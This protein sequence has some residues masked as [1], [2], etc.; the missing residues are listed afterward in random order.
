MCINQDNILVSTTSTRI[1]QQISFRFAAGFINLPTQNH[2][3]AEV[4]N[5]RS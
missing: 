3:E 4:K 2:T 5:G 1:Q